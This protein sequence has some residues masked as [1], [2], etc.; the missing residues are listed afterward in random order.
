[1]SA[2]GEGYKTHTPRK[3][4]NEYGDKF[5]KG[6]GNK[7]GM[8]TNIDTS[9]FIKDDIY[10]DQN[11]T[12]GLTQNL[13]GTVFKAGEIRDGEAILSPKQDMIINGFVN[14]D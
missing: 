5:D 8:V 4:S 13:D 1:M 6:F 14:K 11:N 10:L 7:K 9:G 3:V 2:T 12:G